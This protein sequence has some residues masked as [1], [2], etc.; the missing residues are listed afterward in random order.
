MD[1]V[2]SSRGHGEEHQVGRIAAPARGGGGQACQ[3][4]G[5]GPPAHSRNGCGHSSDKEIVKGQGEKRKGCGDQS[6]EGEA[7]EGEGEGEQEEKTGEGDGEG[8]SCSSATRLRDAVSRMQVSQR[9][10]KAEGI[11]TSALPA[12]RKQ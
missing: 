1:V 7:E 9:I 3:A 8:E 2:C 5:P 10:R 12:S 11:Q 4:S 6:S